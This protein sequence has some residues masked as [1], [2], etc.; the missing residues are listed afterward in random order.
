MS[1]TPDTE[2]VTEPHPETRGTVFIV[3]VFLLGTAA[4]WAFTFYLLID[5]G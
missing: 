2:P 1:T 5:R 4:L 3:A